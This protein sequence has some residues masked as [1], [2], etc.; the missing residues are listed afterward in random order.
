MMLHKT[1]LSHGSTIEEFFVDVQTL[2]SNPLDLHR[3]TDDADVSALVEDAKNIFVKDKSLVDD[4][5]QKQMKKQEEK[6]EEKGEEEIIEQREGR[7]EG[8]ANCSKDRIS[9]NSY[10]EKELE[11]EEDNEIYHHPKDHICTV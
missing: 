3:A 4:E 7:K 1:H 6:R 10:Y 8:K 9:G 5:E 2:A 11:A